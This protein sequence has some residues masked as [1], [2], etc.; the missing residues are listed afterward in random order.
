MIPC[1][2]CNLLDSNLRMAQ[3]VGIK[4]EIERYQRELHEHQVMHLLN[5]FFRA[6]VCV[7]DVRNAK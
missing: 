3:A 4:P 1:L 2:L 6:L 5:A 7:V